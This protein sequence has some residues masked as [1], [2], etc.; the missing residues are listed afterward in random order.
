MNSVRIESGNITDHL[1]KEL[2]QILNDNPTALKEVLH[3]VEEAQAAVAAA[4]KGK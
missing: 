2:D 1:L 4:G 3:A